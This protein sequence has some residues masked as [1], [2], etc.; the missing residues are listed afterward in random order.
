M[1]EK[2]QNSGLSF[3][4]AAGLLFV[5]VLVLY[6]YVHAVPQADTLMFLESR[7]TMSLAEYLSWRYHTITGRL[8]LEAI[9]YLVLGFP[10]PVFAVLDSLIILAGCGLLFHV[11]DWKP[12]TCG[13]FLLACCF[14]PAFGLAEVGIQPGSIN[15]L[16]ALVFA[17]FGL[18]PIKRYRPGEGM[19]LGGLILCLLAEVIGCNMEQMAAIVFAFYTIYPLLELVEKR[20]PPF[21]WLAGWGIAAASLAFLLTCPGTAGRVAHETAMWWP[22]YPELD[23]SSKLWYGWC[24]TIHEVFAVPGFPMF[25][26]S[27]SLGCFYLRGRERLTLAAAVSFLPAVL[28]SLVSLLTYWG[29]ETALHLRG[30][31]WGLEYYVNEGA[32]HEDI[33]A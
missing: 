31:L 6:H 13:V 14:F 22:E 16:W 26:L 27:L 2:V 11:M 25:F 17:G 28:L 23:F 32:A 5:L 20:R 21:A 15:Y 7:E 29:T 30:L 3:L 19:S 10:Y 4:L 1:K 33:K 24:T 9:L 12:K 18:L 8:I